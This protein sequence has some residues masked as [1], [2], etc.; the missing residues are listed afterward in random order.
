MSNAKRAESTMNAIKELIINQRLHPGDGL[1]T[2]TKLCELLG[3]SRSSVREA[4]RKL[5]ALNIVTVEHG[6]GSF[7]GSLSMEP[8][9]QTLA[10]RAVLQGSGDFTG[11]RDVVEVRR[12]LDLGCAEQVVANLKGTTQ[13][14]LQELVDQMLSLARQG[15]TF[16]EQD[17]VFH[18]GLVAGISNTVVK[19]LI[20]SLWLVHQ[21]VVPQLGLEISPHLEDTARAHQAILDAAIAGDV[22]AYRQA[23]IVHYEPLERILRTHL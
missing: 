21:A 5:E 9:V 20:H 4:L 7:V 16:Q 2:E 22:E 6:R 1:P 3:V 23:I 12:Y 14:H 17:I 10:F 19:Q 15:Q 8:L 13:P 11:L 18:L